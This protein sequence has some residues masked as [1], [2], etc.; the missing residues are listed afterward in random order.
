MTTR[1]LNQMTKEAEPLKVMRNIA[2]IFFGIILLVVLFL[3]KPVDFACKHLYTA[4]RQ[5]FFFAI[6]IASII[7]V[8]V[9]AC[10]LNRKFASSRKLLVRESTFVLLI[11]ACSIVLLLVQCYIVR[12]MWFETGWDV[13]AMVSIDAPD[14][15]TTYLSQYPNQVFL[16]GLFRIIGKMGPLFGLQ[17]DYLSLVLGGCVCVTL[18]IWFSAQAARSLFGYMVGY[19][20]FAVSFCFVGLSPWILVPYSDSYGILCPSIVLFCYCCL[21][22]SRVKWA[23]MAFFSFVGYSIKPTAIFV[24]LA[25]LFVELCLAV[26]RRD[27]ARRRLNAALYSAFDALL[28]FLLG[29]A[30]AFGATAA[31]KS[32]GPELDSEKAYSMTHFL[33]MGANAQTQG[34][35]SEDDVA[36]SR[37]CSDKASRQAM[38]IQ[39]WESRITEMGPLGLV[40]LS[41]KKTLCNFADG[42]F[43]WADEGRFWV[44]L[45]GD[46]ESAAS[47]YGIGSFSSADDETT[48]AKLFQSVS[49]V[50]WLMVLC[51]IAL[52]LLRKKTE[53][54]ELAAYLALAALA[55]FLTIFECRARYLYLYA[56][57]FVMLGIAGWVGL[58]RRVK[59]VACGGG[60]YYRR[61]SRLIATHAD[62]SERKI[63]D[64]D[65]ISF[66]LGA[67]RL[68]WSRF[69]GRKNKLLQATSRSRSHGAL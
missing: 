46:N 51:G 41:L 69:L 28:P 25:L 61:D 21:S 58:Y 5:W 11:S 12:L 19:V 16:Y 3:S 43:S 9:A 33:M 39:E 8:F 18:A 35:F 30:L 65:K 2:A 23:L 26:F 60:R 59:T 56:P 36:A 32:L 68:D 47:Y 24:L 37:Q 1:T 31:V 29:F 42:T 4:D 50:T 22:N 54:G 63:G 20:T 57:I 45:H 6:G 49:Q 34:I 14:T 7:A 13:G 64:A 44:A 55:I 53:R 38:N 27:T 62:G 15:M 66:Q 40:E 67:G 48:N 52:G 10:L 17:S